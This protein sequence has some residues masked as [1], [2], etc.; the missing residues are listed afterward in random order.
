MKAGHI[1]ISVVDDDPALRESIVGY[2]RTVGHFECVSQYNGAEEA[3]AKLPVDNPDVILL[4]IKMKGI[5]G[6]ECVQRLKARMPSAKVIMLT[7]FEETD[8]IFR[9]LRAGADGY[10]LKRQPPAK[11]VEAIYEV[12]EGGA[13]MSAPIARKVVEFLQKSVV[14]RST[15]KG[16][17]KLALSPREREVLERLAAGQVYKQVADGM[18]ISVHTVRSYIRRIYEKLH[19]HTRAEAVAKYLR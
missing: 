19:V 14:D 2:L 5:D 17:E 10:L 7:V 13:P 3:L 15:G 12:V 9:A 6:I 11:L 1:T 4:D 16:A 8:L 18:N